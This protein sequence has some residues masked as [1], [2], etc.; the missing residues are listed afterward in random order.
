MGAFITC[1]WFEK[2]HAKRKDDTRFGNMAVCT[3]MYREWAPGCYN[4]KD[5]RVIQDVEDKIERAISNLPEWHIKG[6]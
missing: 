2:C 1:Q 6:K 5:Q 4:T 3:T